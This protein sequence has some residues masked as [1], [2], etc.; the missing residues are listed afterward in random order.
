MNRENELP[1]IGSSWGKW[2]LHVHTPFS[3]HHNYGGDDDV[4]WEK[5]IQDLEAL[6]PEFKVLGINDYL[7]LDGY[8]KLKK[9]KEENGRL[10]KIDLLLPVLEFRIKK[11]AGVEFGNFKRINLHVIFSDAINV[12][13]IE[14]QFLSSLQSKYTR[15]DGTEFSRAI[16]RDT[17]AELGVEI[18]HDVPLGELDK[19]GSD[20]EEGFNNLNVDEEA[21]MALLESRDCFKDK[22]LIAIGK[23][24]WDALNW[25]NGSIADKKSII[26]K[27]DIIFTASE[28]VEVF[29]KAKEK[30][31]SQ[32]VKD[33]LLDCSD[34]HSFSDSDNKDRIGNCNTWIKADSTFEG[35]KQIKYEPQLGVRH[36]IKEDFPKKPIN[37]IDSLTFNIPADA[38]I[39]EDL[40]CF[41][42]NN[43]TYH[44]SPY[45]NCFVGGRG[46]GKSTILNFLGLHSNNPESPEKFWVDLNPDFNPKDKEPFSFRGTEIFEFL[47]QSKIEDFA[48]DKVKFTGA[49]YDRI[50]GPGKILQSFEENIDESNNLF[51]KIVESVFDRQELLNQKINKGKEQRSLE[52]TK[53][54]INSQDYKDI[55]RKIS[56][57]TK[58]IQI[59]EKWSKETYLLKTHLGDV[60]NLYSEILKENSDNIEYKTSYLLAIEKINLAITLLEE[61]N[62]EAPRAEQKILNDQLL[63]LESELKKLLDK[64]NFS[65]EN[66]EQIKSAPYKIS[67]LERDIEQI[68]AQI[69]AKDKTIDNLNNIIEKVE[70]DKNSY[71]EKIRNI[72]EPLQSLLEKQFE[73]NEGRDIKKISLQYYFNKNKAWEDLTREFFK[74][75]SDSFDEAVKEKYV[76]DYIIDNKTIFE[77]DSLE[78]IQTLIKESIKGDKQY[79]KFLDEIFS[80]E[81]Y[82]QAFRAIRSK[83]LHD[84]KTNKIIQ[85][86]YD[87]KDVEQVSFGQRCTAVVVVLILFGNNPLIIDEPEAHLDSSLIA[88]YLVPLLKKNKTDRQ[89]I[90][91]T[92]NAN[93]VINGDAEKIFILKNEHGITEVI[94]TTIENIKNRPE[95]LKLEGGKE[96]F[97]KRGEKL[98]IE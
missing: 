16:N 95:L 82:F 84:V 76:C 15:N 43:H 19:F 9:E 21:L 71:E 53:N 11:F 67:E 68:T 64:G 33:L 72:I 8:K 2:D 81:K 49:I 56:E 92:H 20:L 34:A 87:D 63:L 66:I 50:N 47:A 35:L 6:P 54:I 91:A 94:E 83:Y 41:A 85:V 36:I 58:K 57:I 48:R 3:L 65:E 52:E 79:I 97:K 22:Y 59:H 26:N 37:T 5:F 4:V 38:K 80:N 89:V 42:G 18:K 60:V 46:S 45:F 12:S 1:N 14:S 30:L 61:A 73:D 27:A 28:S 55:T 13:T 31:S 7:F 40:F 10:P 17:L 29:G 32:N 44:L 90:F 24:E 86:K 62:F 98:N 70:L 88:N 51:D 69:S 78:S 74:K 39:G 25:T 23:T 77:S 75:F 93:F 96:A